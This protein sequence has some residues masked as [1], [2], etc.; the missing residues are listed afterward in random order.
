MRA[1]KPVTLTVTA[2]ALPADAEQ[3]FTPGATPERESAEPGTF[4]AE[5][6]G[7]TVSNLTEEQASAMKVSAGGVM[8]TEVDPNGPA[9]EAGLRRGMVILTV[10]Q[11][12]VKGLDSFKAAMEGQSVKDKVLLYVQVRP[13]QNAFVVV[14]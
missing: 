8:I 1:G 3:A 12:E 10:G 2:K 7:V 4:R 11:A 6:L 14:K 5:E 9:Y 13:G